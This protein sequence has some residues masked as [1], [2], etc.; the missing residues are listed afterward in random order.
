M[1]DEFAA[2]V[3]GIGAL[4]EPTRRELYVFVAAQDDAVS[5]EQA[6]A[7][8]GLPVHSA[9]FHLD[10]LVDE[11]LLEVEFRRLSGR[12]GPGRA[13]PPSSTAGPPVRSRSRCRSGAT[14][15]PGRSWPLRSSA[16]PRAARRCVA[17]VGEVARE[18]GRA[19]GA[20]AAPTVAGDREDERAAEALSAL[21]YEPRPRDGGLALANCP[22][23]ALAREHTSLVCGL[24]HA[25]LGGLLDGL[26]CRD[27]EADL[28]PEAGWCCV[29]AR[30]RDARPGPPADG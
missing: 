24:N 7:G 30:L 23:D 8:V 5:R 11:G 15:W 29:R 22:F 28:E 2:R 17:A 25:Y 26:G 9:K 21:G 10:R 6:A 3:S 13:A 1:T 27:L 16:P 20:E 12:T 4:A 14:T 19:A 18:R